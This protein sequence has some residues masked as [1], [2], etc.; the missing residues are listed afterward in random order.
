[1]FVSKI[2]EDGVFLEL[3]EVP[4][5][6]KKL[7]KGYSFSLPPK[8]SKGSYAV[9]RGE[10]K[11]FEGEIPKYPPDIIDRPPEKITQVTMRQARLELLRMNKLKD[12]DEAL[13]SIADEQQRQAAQIEWEYSAVVDRY[14]PLVIALTPA[15]NLT[16]EDMDNLFES[17]SKL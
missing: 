6:T 3:V 12:V 15:L 4:D 8:F 1:M 11:I 14:S 5:E 17:A 13:S 2:R 10:W 16:D 7:P 9:M